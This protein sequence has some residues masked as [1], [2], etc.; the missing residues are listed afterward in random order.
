MFTFLSFILYV[1]LAIYIH[2][3]LPRNK[4]SVTFSLVSLFFAI[5][6]LSMFLLQ[7]QQEIKV[8]YLYDRVAVFSV[9][10]ASVSI[11]IL[12]LFLQSPNHSGYL[13]KAIY[14]FLLPFATILAIRYFIDPAS[15]KFFLLRHN[16]W[17]YLVNKQSPWALPF[18]I[19]ILLGL[20]LALIQTYKW[21]LLSNSNRQRNQTRIVFYALLLFAFTTFLIDVIIPNWDFYLTP[22]MVHIIGVPPFVA[23]LYALT[24]SRFQQFTDEIISGYVMN[25]LPLLIIFVDARDQ[26]FGVNQ[27]A[28]NTLGYGRLE[29]RE[30]P[31][32]RL[33]ADRKECLRLQEK[34]IGGIYLAE[35]MIDLRTKEGLLI[36]AS[37]SCIRL[38]D[39]FGKFIG[40]VLVGINL[41][42]KQILEGE[43]AQAKQQGRLLENKQ[44]ELQFVLQKR[45]QEMGT[46]LVSLENRIGEREYALDQSQHILKTKEDL[47]RE[48]HHRVKNNLQIIN[49]LTNFTGLDER[50]TFEDQGVLLKIVD[51]IRKISAIHD[52]FYASAMMSKIHFG[53][54]I[55]KAV[56]AFQSH[57]RNMINLMIKTDTSDDI[58]PVNQ[59]L[60]CG[61]ILHELVMNALVHAFVDQSVDKEA[62]AGVTSNSL[63]TNSVIR[64][65]FYK[66]KGTYILAVIDNGAGIKEDWREQQFSGTGLHLVE[67]LVKDY[68]KG[69]FL[70]EPSFGTKVT[71]SFPV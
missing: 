43:I 45:N 31:F 22:S 34:V 35:A 12:L 67:T 48:M 57:Y 50:I 26:V 64:I 55:Q 25:N 61:L 11:N 15:I 65:D 16:T 28:Q 52:D 1:Q 58:L 51:R 32:E 33:F 66:R 62:P 70:V 3:K 6:S 38:G 4:I 20:K 23:I 21:H 46:A 24:S 37:V 53:Q 42:Q 9:L 44:K 40:F 27:Y 49:S 56:S 47:V 54:Y 59:A 71:I 60:P 17:F 8:V 41:H 14:Y 68:L 13:K 29:I 69:S 30:L 18:V 36:K 7:Q 19:F 63:E 2:Y 10:S 5:F 39:K